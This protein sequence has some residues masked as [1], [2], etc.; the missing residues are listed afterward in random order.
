MQKKILIYFGTLIFWFV[1]LYFTIIIVRV[2][3]NKLKQTF[4]MSYSKYINGIYALFFVL[5]CITIVFI[6]AISQNNSLKENISQVIILGL[7]ALY[8]SMSRIMIAN[9]IPVSNIIYPQWILWYPYLP[10][11]LGNIVLVCE[12]LLLKKVI[13]KNKKE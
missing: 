1:M 4:D 6:D 13:V 7:P 3:E 11:L 5:L 9:Y 12:I 8:L 2:F 10:M